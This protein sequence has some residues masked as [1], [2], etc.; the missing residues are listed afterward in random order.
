MDEQSASF[1]YKKTDKEIKVKQSVK[2]IGKE[3]NEEGDLATIKN[4]DESMK[5]ALEI[6][7]VKALT[8]VTVK[9]GVFTITYEFSKIATIAIATVFAFLF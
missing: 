8:S 2:K 6:E 5:K 4:D 9:E 1:V 7:E 3:A